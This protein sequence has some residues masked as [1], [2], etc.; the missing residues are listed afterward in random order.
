MQED[1]VGK[2][3]LKTNIAFSLQLVVS[4]GRVEH[5]MYVEQPPTVLGVTSKY[6]GRLDWKRSSATQTQSIFFSFRVSQKVAVF[7]QEKW[8]SM[9]DTHTEVT[10][11]PLEDIDF[12]HQFFL[13]MKVMLVIKLVTKIS[14]KVFTILV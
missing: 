4:K 14:S 7:A 3:S 13:T 10:I 2:C 9:G 11:M 1:C 12:L 8:L 6:H 5:E